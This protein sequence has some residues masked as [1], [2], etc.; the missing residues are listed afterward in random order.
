M[1]ITLARPPAV[2]L[3]V[4]ALAG[5]GGLLNDDALAATP[6]A[7]SS[8]PAGFWEHWGDGQAELAGYRLTQPRYGALRSGE[9]VLITVTE[10]FLPGPLVKAERGQADRFPVVKLNE[11]RDFQTGMY[12]YNVMA[13]VFVPLD[14]RLARGLP[15]KVSFTSQEWC[16]HVYDAVT[17]RGDE[18]RHVWH[19]YFDGEAD[20]QVTLRSPVN[21]LAVDAMPLLARDL[22]GPLVAPGQARPV[23]VWTRAMDRRFT[24]RDPGFLDATLRREAETRTVEV[25][26]GSFDIRR[27]TLEIADRTG[28]WDVEVAPPHR[29]IR[30]AWSD[31][32]R[33]EL[34]GAMRA[35]YWQRSAPGDEGLRQPLGLER[36]GGP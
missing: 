25:P 6:L 36:V 26:A 15:V 8:A 21:A 30:W 18:V 34:T 9:A 5:C 17:W 2:L 10:D 28:T 4:V 7:P 20:G 33:G 13:S 35:P 19:S 23:R 31:G 27:T 12:D 11:V 24:H 32:E 29:L 14:G 3:A 22:A 16:G 1:P